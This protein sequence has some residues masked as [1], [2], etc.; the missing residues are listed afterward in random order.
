MRRSIAAL[1]LTAAFL[2]ISTLASAQTDAGSLERMRSALRASQDLVV[3]P[4]ALPPLTGPGTKLWGGL[5]LMHPDVTRGEMIRVAVPAGDF[6]MRAA[7]AVAAA[8]HRRVVLRAHEEVERAL[9][10]CLRHE[11]R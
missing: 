3:T 10:D 5:T 2:A 8:H 9:T 11:L 4:P 1:A 7:R 6:T